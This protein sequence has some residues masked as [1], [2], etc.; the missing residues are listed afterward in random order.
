[1]GLVL[2]LGGLVG[3]QMLMFFSGLG[4]LRGIFEVNLAMLSVSYGLS[5]EEELASIFPGSED[6]VW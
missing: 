4:E 5:A 3:G 1:M 2:G 6:S